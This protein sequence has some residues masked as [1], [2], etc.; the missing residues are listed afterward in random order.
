MPQRSALRSFD[1]KHLSWQESPPSTQPGTHNATED[2][3]IRPYQTRRIAERGVSRRERDAMRTVTV[4]ASRAPRAVERA[5]VRASGVAWSYDRVEQRT[6]FN[7][8]V[9]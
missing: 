6:V 2:H 9:L 7:G 3:K 5:V 1:V 4:N 8:C